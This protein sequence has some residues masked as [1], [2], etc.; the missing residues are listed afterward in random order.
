[1]IESV[2]EIDRDG[3]S[4]PFDRNRI[5]IV[6]TPQ[7]FRAELLHEAYRRPYDERF[8]DDASVVEATGHTIRLVEGNRENIKLTTPMDLRYAEIMSGNG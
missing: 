4:R 7:V 2:R 3:R 5:C 8:T 6:Q 1:M